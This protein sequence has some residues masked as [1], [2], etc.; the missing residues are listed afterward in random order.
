MNSH[1]LC[2]ALRLSAYLPETMLQSQPCAHASEASVPR[3]AARRQNHAPVATSASPPPI[4]ARPTSRFVP[5]ADDVEVTDRCVGCAASAG[6]GAAAG[7]GA[8]GIVVGA[9]LVATG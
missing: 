9:G 2:C 4:T 8:T 3:L 7:V 5:S 6:A 1:S